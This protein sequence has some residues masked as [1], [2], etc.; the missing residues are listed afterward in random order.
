MTVVMERPQVAPPP[1]FGFLRKMTQ[2]FLVLPAFA[3]AYL[4]AAPTGLGRRVRDLLIAGAALVMSAGW[5]VALVSLWPASSPL[6]AVGARVL[7]SYRSAL[8]A[9][10]VLAAMVLAS[11]GWAWVL[12]GRVSW[13][14]GLRWGALPGRAAGRA[15]TP[16]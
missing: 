4:V 13:M 9:R 5:Y 1:G 14:P 8:G 12:L 3:L 10:L 6:V 2:A 7:W 15:P 16:S 11:A